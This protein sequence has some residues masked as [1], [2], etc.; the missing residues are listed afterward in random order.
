MKL[1]K[2][3]NRIFKNKKKADVNTIRTYN[4]F[5]NR[6]NREIKNSKKKYYADYSLL[7]TIIISKRLGKASET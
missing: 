2:K 6:I 5:R 1:I 3:R 4:L 7:S